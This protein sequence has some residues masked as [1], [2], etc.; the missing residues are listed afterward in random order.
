[1]S[2]NLSARQLLHP[3]IEL[4]V[5]G[6][7]TPTQRDELLVLGCTIGQGFYYAEPAPADLITADRWIAGV[8]ASLRGSDER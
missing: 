7:E 8:P 3:D 4:I 5:R 6:I 2:I 1:M